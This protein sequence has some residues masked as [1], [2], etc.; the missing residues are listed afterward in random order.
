MLALSRYLGIL[1]QH[2]GLRVPSAEFF[3]EG[4]ALGEL[5]NSKLNPK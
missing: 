1:I 4:A 3:W 5:G 2:L